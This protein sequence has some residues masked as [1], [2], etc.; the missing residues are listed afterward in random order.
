MEF[1]GGY[2]ALARAFVRSSVLPQPT[3]ATHLA[4]SDDDG[5][6]GEDPAEEKGLLRRRDGDTGASRDF[7]F[8]FGGRS[9]LQKRKIGLFGIFCSEQL[10][11]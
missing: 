3:K 4:R 10:I 8:M 7:C 11:Q 9:F 5:D 2:V 1:P 6:G